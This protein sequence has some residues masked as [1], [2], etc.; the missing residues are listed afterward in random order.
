VFAALLPLD[1]RISTARRSI[2]LSG[3]VRREVEAL[4][5]FGQGASALL[6][7]VTI[8]LIDPRNR[9]RLADLAAGYAFA[10]LIVILAKGLIGRP[11]PKFEDPIYFLG[12][13]GQYPI[14][15]VRNGRSVGVHHA[16][17]LGSGI[18]SDLWSMPS[19]HTAYAVATALFVA[20][21]YPKL[22]TLMLALALFVG[23][24]RVLT[25]AHYPTDVLVGGAIGLFATQLALDGQWGQRLLAKLRP[26]RSPA[27]TV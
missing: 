10:A 18:S 21:L 17:D 9:R 13:L 26:A 3:D 2:H 7:V 8:W 12:P 11:R 14:N 6:I 24:A 4:Q 25:G 15:E 1:G 20:T 16:W 27:E 23:V 19:S 5:Q 22:R